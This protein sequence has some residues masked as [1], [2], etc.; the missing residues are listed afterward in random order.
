VTPLRP[1]H[2]LSLL[3]SSSDTQAAYMLPLSSGSVSLLH[4]VSLSQSLSL[5]SVS[6]CLSPSGLLCP[7]C[8]SLSLCVKCL[9][10]TL[11]L[12]VSLC[13]SLSLSVYLLSLYAPSSFSFDIYNLYS[14]GNVLCLSRPVSQQ[15]HAFGS[16]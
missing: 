16:R 14:S 10:Y 8:L 1:H 9:I 13:L 4:Q 12:S 11:S 2:G 7:F 3:S 5:S 6:L 15:E